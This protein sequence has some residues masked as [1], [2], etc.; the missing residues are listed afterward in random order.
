MLDHHGRIGVPG[1]ECGQ[2]PGRDTQ[3]PSARASRPRGCS[4][5][6]SVGRPWS[7]SS[8]SSRAPGPRPSRLRWPSRTQHSFGGSFLAGS[9]P[10]F[11]SKYAFLNVFR[12]LQENH[13]LANKF[14]KCL[15]KICKIF[16]KFS[17]FW[18][19]L[20]NFAK[21]SEIRKMFAKFCRNNLQKFVD[22]EKC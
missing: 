2:P 22:F 20:Q 7:R 12:N 11:A 8:T 17:I 10:I 13:L 19:F 14:C 21:F 6:S 5:S 4:S 9:K 15:Q 1:L 18:Q 3:R 16:H